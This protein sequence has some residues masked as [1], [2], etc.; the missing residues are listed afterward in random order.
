VTSDW[1][2]ALEPG[3]PDVVAAWRGIE[4]EQFITVRR[5]VRRRAGTGSADRVLAQLDHLADA[6]IRIVEGL[7]DEA[8]ALPG[9]EEDWNVAQTVG[10]VASARAGLVMAASLA[11]AGRWPSDAPTVIPGIPGPDAGRDDL[12][13]RLRQSQRIIARVAAQI[14]GHEK[15]PCPLHHP[16]VGHLRCGEWLLFAGVHDVMHLEQLHAIADKTGA[17]A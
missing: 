9:G 12:V 7:T 13:R 4:A 15:D 11:A 17:P 1:P 2:T 6:L 8:L 10:H 16:L 14:A 3:A 5:E